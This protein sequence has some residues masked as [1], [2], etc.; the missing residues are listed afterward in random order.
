M[1]VFKLIEYDKL[2][3]NKS[4]SHQSQTETVEFYFE[5]RILKYMSR[6]KSSLLSLLYPNPGNTSVKLHFLKHSTI[7]N[8]KLSLI[9]S[10]NTEYSLFCQLNVQMIPVL[11]IFG[12]LINGK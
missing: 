6:G 12:I 8:V 9:L 11:Q 3:R 1:S 2:S 5:H 4:Y 10:L 7:S